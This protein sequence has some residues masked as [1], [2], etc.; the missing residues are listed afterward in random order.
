MYFF[1]LKK[2]E[3]ILHELI[4]LLEING[5]KDYW[6]IEKL[7]KITVVYKTFNTFIDYSKHRDSFGWIY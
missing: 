2:N 4:N 5:S 6:Y 3:L 7:S 1:D